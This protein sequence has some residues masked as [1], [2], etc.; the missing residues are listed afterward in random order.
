[1]IIKEHVD[2][3]K[4]LNTSLNVN[5]LPYSL[6][7]G[8]PFKKPFLNQIRFPKFKLLQMIDEIILTNYL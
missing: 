6:A 7:A 3:R 5:I 2:I 1:M 4:K 8:K